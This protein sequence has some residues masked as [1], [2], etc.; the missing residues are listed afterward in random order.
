MDSNSL[1][2]YTNVIVGA[3]VGFG[4]WAIFFYKNKRKADDYSEALEVYKVYIEEIR[5]DFR[6]LKI[7]YDKLQGYYFQEKQEKLE[8]ALKLKDKDDG[9]GL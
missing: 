9:K 1:P 2:W 4:Q 6:D 3:V 5:K 8:L 7:N